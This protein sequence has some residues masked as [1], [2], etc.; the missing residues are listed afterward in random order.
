MKKQT[1]GRIQT[2][3]IV[4]FCLYLAGLVYFLFFSE[5]FGRIPGD[6][7]HY[8]L[9]PL[10]EIRRFWAYRETLGFQAVVL[11]LAGNICGFVPF[12]ALL[13][14]MHRSMRSGLRVFLAGF[15][16]SACVELLQL[17]TRLGSLD[18]DDILLN[19]L[20]AWL[21]YGIFRLCNRFRRKWYG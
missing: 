8:N 3:G 20:G 10:R 17:F 6:E 13:P 11:N 4:L 15:L 16:F 7:M 9:R 14:V 19:T 21:G 12:G 1:A 2:A 5:N 18:V